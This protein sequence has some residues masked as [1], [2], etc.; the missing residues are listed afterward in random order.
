MHV[1][2]L[3]SA[4]SELERKFSKRTLR[5]KDVNILAAFWDQATYIC[6]NRKCQHIQSNY[7]SYVTRLQN[8]IETLKQELAEYRK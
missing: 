4:P 2:I 1:Q 7:Q 5:R 8:E 6:T 3:V